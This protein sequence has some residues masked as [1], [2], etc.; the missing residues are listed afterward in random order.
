MFKHSLTFTSA[1]VALLSTT[2]VV[3]CGDDGGGTPERPDAQPRP[4]AMPVPDAPP[5][6]MRIDVPAGD[7]TTATTWTAPNTYVLKG[8][9]F[10]RGVTLTIQPGVVVE[11]DNGS[12]LVI[13]NDGKLEAAG[14]A[15]A[16]IVFTSSQPAAMRTRADW[17][18]VVLLGKA[19]IN[20]TGGTQTV[21]GFPAGTDPLRIGYGGADNTHDCGTVK[22]ARIEYAGFKLDQDKEI[23]GLTLGA[24]GTGTEIDYVQV[25]LGA[26]DG[27]ELFGGSADLKHVLITQSDDDGIDW[28]FGWTGKA[29]FVVVQQSATNGDR[30]MECDNNPTSQD[31]LPRSNPQIWNYT[32]V[33]GGANGMSQ[34][35]LVFKNGSG[36]S[37][38][39]GV[40]MN[41]KSAAIDV[42]GVATITQWGTGL[43]VNRSFLYNEAGVGELWPI[44]FE[45]AQD[46]IDE[47]VELAAVARNNQVG[48]NP[49]LTAPSSMTAP[50][51]APMAGSPALSCGT[52]PAGFDTTAT[53]CGGV[54]AT[55]WTTGWTA[56]PANN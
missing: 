11:G 45:S 26:D 49:M 43:T 22:Y 1:L 3:G 24:C 31:L 55:D 25:H 42:Q 34:E 35:G 14:T 48:V 30:G 12:A 29:Q 2:M 33:G 18:G 9:V 54:G 56:F 16:P 4:D 17:G 7:L 32:L 36:G 51:F 39:N 10:V 50:S 5:G 47:A 21:E 8:Q 52:P 23:N 53:F 41:F 13:S 46:A 6:A 27:I 38:N 15:A 44:G 19:P 37:L 20:V 40:I 28:D